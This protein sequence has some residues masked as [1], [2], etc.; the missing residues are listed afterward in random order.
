MEQ[1][2]VE[3]HITD[4]ESEALY[5][6]GQILGRE[7]SRE[8]FNGI[9]GGKNSTYSSDPSNYETPESYIA[10]WRKKHDARYEREK[11]YSHDMSSHRIHKLLQDEFVSEYIDNY[12]ARTYFRKHK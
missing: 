7:V 8:S 4:N 11:N 3:R 5:R 10:D 9:I 6:A 12:L 1:K 2:E